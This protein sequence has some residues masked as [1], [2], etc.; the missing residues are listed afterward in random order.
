MT[1][2]TDQRDAITAALAAFGNL[3]LA[4]AACHLFATLG[5]RSEKRLALDNTPG[6]FL[7]QFDHPEALRLFLLSNHYRSPVDFSLQNMVEARISLDRASVVEGPSDPGRAQEEY[8][9]ARLFQAVTSLRQLAAQPGD[10]VVAIVR[11][12]PEAIIADGWVVD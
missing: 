3:P 4:T 10:R 8:F 9:I 2:T 12:S 7:A 1:A 11:N 6:A 5:Y